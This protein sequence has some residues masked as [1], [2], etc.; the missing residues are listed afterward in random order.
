LFTVRPELTIFV[1]HN[2]QDGIRM[3]E[4]VDRFFEFGVPL[5]DL[6]L[7]ALEQNVFG[8]LSTIKGLEAQPVLRI[9]SEGKEFEVGSDAP[10][11]NSILQ[12]HCQVLPIWSL[13]RYLS[14]AFLAQ[15]SVLIEC[16]APVINDGSL[17]N[18]IRE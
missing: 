15:R 5:N 12:Q 17:W 16:S 11:F 6:S 3:S 8:V 1:R 13:I 14:I 7:V 9:E 10:Y 18:G 4:G 2:I